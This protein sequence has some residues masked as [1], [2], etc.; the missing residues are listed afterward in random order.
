MI[1][2][3]L[4]VITTTPAVS[5]YGCFIVIISMCVI[6][7]IPV[8]IKYSLFTGDALDIVWSREAHHYPVINLYLRKQYVSLQRNLLVFIITL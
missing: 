3:D 4:R 7:G 6:V 8:R 2:V 1:N 5:A